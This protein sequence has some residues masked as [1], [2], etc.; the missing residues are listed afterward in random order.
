MI[1]AGRA[2]GTILEGLASRYPTRI[3]D[4]YLYG[5]LVSNANHV[6]IRNNVIGNTFKR[7]TAFAAGQLYSVVPDSGIL[8][9]QSKYVDI[10]DNSVRQGARAATQWVIAMR[11]A[12]YRFMVPSIADYEVRRELIRAGK[13][14][15]I[16]Q[17]D[18]FNAAAPGWA[19]AKRSISASRLRAQQCE[20]HV[21]HGS[22][23]CD[24]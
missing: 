1:L 22:H 6:E 24:T 17:L 19:S 7:G 9:G 5:I 3:D 14:R 16:L 4:C 23:R 21:A 20:I 2:A 18:A 12:G 10:R 8:I 11:A 13:T 15:S